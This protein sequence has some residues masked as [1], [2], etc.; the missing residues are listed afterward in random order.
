[1]KKPQDK[2]AK[3]TLNIGYSTVAPPI[4]GA[5]M[6]FGRERN[7][8]FWAG[9]AIVISM[10]VLTAV[11]LDRVEKK[12]S[13][14]E[15]VA[16]SIGFIYFSMVCALSFVGFESN[17]FAWVLASTQIFGAFLSLIG[18]VRS[19]KNKN[20]GLNQSVDTTPVSAPH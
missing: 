4:L 11:M 9:S 1:M 10:L 19:I 15:T 18:I 3:W 12:K 8:I 13:K 5:F 7:E 6:T 14:N 16:W 2:L 17:G 20:E